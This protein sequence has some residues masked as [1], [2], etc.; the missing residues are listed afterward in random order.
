VNMQRPTHFYPSAPKLEHFLLKPTNLKALTES[1]TGTDNAGHSSRTEFAPLD[2]NQYSNYIS[3]HNYWL[4]QIEAVDNLLHAQALR[5]RALK[6]FRE[7]IH[8]DLS[9]P[10]DDLA[11]DP[12]SV[13]GYSADI[14]VILQKKVAHP[15]ELSTKPHRAE[16]RANRKKVR[17]AAVKA[18]A[19]ALKAKAE[20]I[21]ET[22]TAPL[23]KDRLVAINK[24]SDAR[25]LHKAELSAAKNAA[26]RAKQIRF[27]STDLVV[28]V[29]PDDGWK[30]VTRRKGE[31][32]P[33][34]AQAWTIDQ[35][36]GQLFKAGVQRDP[37]VPQSV[38]PLVA[39]RK[40]TATASK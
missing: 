20:V 18:A 35:A 25:P 9:N 3:S 10:Q 30:L 15:P 16:K 5:R 29:A 39:I 7:A 24:L 6:G 13:P 23:I 4:S 28:N 2:A 31:F 11:R 40:P 1:A 33:D 36:T 19:E 22:K 32:R 17:D 38:V 14:N 27:G 12:I 8:V 26:A 34:L 37:A 21:A